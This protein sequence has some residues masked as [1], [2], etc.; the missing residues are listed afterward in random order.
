MKKPVYGFEQ[1]Y[2]VDENG[3]LYSK[4]D[5]FLSPK[6]PAAQASGRQNRY[7]LSDGKYYDAKYLVFKSFYPEIDVLINDERIIFK[8][9]N[10]RDNS[11]ANLRML[12]Q[13][14][15]EDIALL[16]SEKYDEEIRPMKDFNNY[17]ISEYGNIYSYYRS[18]SKLIK[19]YVG[20]DGYYQVRIPDGYGTDTHIKIHKWVAKT[21]LSNPNQYNVV[22]HKDENKLNNHYSNLEWTTLTQNTIYSMGKKCCMLDKNNH[23]LSIHDTISDLSRFYRVDSSTASKQC[24]GRKNQFTNGWKARFFNSDTHSFVPTKFD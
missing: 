1:N 23:I 4:K 14:S 19:P 15:R 18:T 6:K 8:N 22:H 2:R 24:N 13:D 21:F 17:Y 16:L 7:R 20:T 3:N 9:G 10:V 5:N 11:I 12:N